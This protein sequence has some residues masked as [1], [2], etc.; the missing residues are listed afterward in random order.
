MRRTDDVILWPWLFT[1]E[2]TAIVGD[3]RLGTLSE[4]HYCNF[5][6][7]Y[8]YSFSIYWPFGQHGSDWSR[9]HAIL[10]FDL[11]GHGACG[12]CGSSSSIRLPSLKFVGLAIRKILRTMCVSISGPGDLDRWPFDLET[13]MQVASKVGNLYSEFQHARPSGSRV[14][15]YVR[16][17]RTDKS[18]AYCTLPYER[19][20]NN[21]TLVF[22]QRQRQTRTRAGWINAQYDRLTPG[23]T[24]SVIVRQSQRVCWFI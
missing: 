12:W 5:W 20:H 18:N 22:R 10:T 15:R 23:I 7:Y 1:L 14:I 3:E 17:G 21:I 16:D 24:Q 19:R 11:G 13:R 9:D 8:D 6:W 2:V 4:Y